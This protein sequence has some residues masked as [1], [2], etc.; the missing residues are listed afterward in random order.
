VKNNSSVTD[1]LTATRKSVF[2][3]S[4][5]SPSQSFIFFY[6]GGIAVVWLGQRIK[7]AVNGTGAVGE[8][9]AMKQF[10]KVG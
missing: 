4:K 1:A 10:P 9:V 7:P 5:F 2:S 3:E 6:R 8:Y